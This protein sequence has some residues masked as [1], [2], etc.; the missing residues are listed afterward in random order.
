MWKRKIAKIL[1]IS[2]LVLSVVII[3]A[4]TFRQKS[5]DE[6]ISLS[7]FV[8]AQSQPNVTCLNYHYGG[9]QFNTTITAVYQNMENFEVHGTV[10]GTLKTSQ[11]SQPLTKTSDRI[12][13]GPN[14]QYATVTLTF[15][16]V[17][18]QMGYA[19]F[20]KF[21][22]EE[23]V[24]A[25]H[26]TGGTTTG[27]TGSFNTRNPTAVAEGGGFDYASLTLAISAVIIVVLCSL[28][29]VVVLKKRGI[30]E[31]KVKRFT[32]YEF[33]DWVLQRL[34]G[35]AG[36]VLDSRKGI[37]GFTDNNVPISIKQ[38]D[39]VAKLQVDV[40]MNNLMQAKV[41]SGVMVAFG[42]SS[43]A[44][45]AVSRARMNRIDIKLVT[46]KELIER[47]EIAII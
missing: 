40:F 39:E 17:P 8:A 27:S 36:S 32:S 10:I 46:V 35:H 33:Q 45:A 26:A 42:F 18:N 23:T 31:Q 22:A 47:K 5:N 28:G 16:G 7:F 34:H 43:E 1:L 41:R 13:I 29:G 37:D 11:N 38:S 24:T 14:G 25:S 21:T 6:R 4:P 2:V 12:T 20:V 44:N 3:S 19:S 15:V 9:N 30:S